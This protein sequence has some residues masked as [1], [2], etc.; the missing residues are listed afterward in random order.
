MNYV[1]QKQWWATAAATLVAVVGDYDSAVV[2]DY[3]S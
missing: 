3:D 2:G 1:L